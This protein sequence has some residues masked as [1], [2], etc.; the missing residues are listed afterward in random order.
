MHP[1]FGVTSHFPS[2]HSQL[3]TPSSLQCSFVRASGQEHLLNST[4][5]V[6]AKAKR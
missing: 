1:G 3:L 6:K 5:V 2:F 4:F